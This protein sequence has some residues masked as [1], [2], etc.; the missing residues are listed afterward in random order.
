MANSPEQKIFP[1][2]ELV[3][4][5]NI[6]RP[7]LRKILQVLN[8]KGVLKSYKGQGGGFRLALSPRKIFIVDLMEIFQGP[9]KLNECIVKTRICHDIRTCLLKKKIE[10]IGRHITSELKTITVSSLLNGR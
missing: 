1:V 2:Y 3:K 10:D 4:E 7:F 8:K 9:L 6:P 5:L